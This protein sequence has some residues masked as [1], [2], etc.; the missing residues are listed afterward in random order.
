MDRFFSEIKGTADKVVKKSGEL[1]ELSK[2]KISISSTKSE[3]ST[4]YKK[5][6]ELVYLMQKEEG[7]T[8]TE[9]FDEIIS[10]ID[11]LNEKLTE[12]LDLCSSLKNEKICPECSKSNDKNSQFCSKCGYKF[13]VFSDDEDDFVVED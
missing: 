10:K 5:L 7:S 11:E 2:I 3:I 12:L 1:F 6:G 4:N 8:N 13:P 9:E